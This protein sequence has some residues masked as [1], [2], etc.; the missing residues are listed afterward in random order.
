VLAAVRHT[1]GDGFDSLLPLPFVLIFHRLGLRLALHPGLCSTAVLYVLG[2]GPM[3]VIGYSVACLQQIRRLG[4]QEAEHQAEATH[5][6][7][8]GLHNRGTLLGQLQAALDRSTATGPAVAVL[9]LDLDG[10]KQVNDTFGHEA[11]DLVL[12]AVASALR[13]SVLGSDTIGRLGGDEFAVVLS[14]VR[15][16]GQAEAVAAGILEELAEPIMISGHP[17]PIGGSIGIALAGRPGAGAAE[18]LRRAG[19]AMY[20]AKRSRGSRWAV[21]RPHLEPAARVSPQ[22]LRAAVTTGQL[23]LAYQP[24]V[25][26]ATGRIAGAEALVRWDHPTRGP[27]PPAEFVPV[28]QESGLIGLVGEWVMRTACLQLAAWRAGIPGAGRIWLGVNVA[29]EQLQDPRTAGSVVALIEGLGIPPDR[30]VLEVTETVLMGSAMARISLEALHEAGVRIAIDDFGTGY[31]ALPY[32]TRLPVDALKLDRAFVAEL[33][34]GGE[35]AA[36]A[37]AVVRLAHTLRVGCTAEGVET[38]AQA[39]ELRALGYPTAQ[40]YYFGAPLSAERLT[41]LL[42]D[43][44]PLAAVPG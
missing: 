13:R 35:G 14:N 42:A 44:A 29:A 21:Y 30:L 34:G 38:A 2:W 41:L 26:L 1:L 5:D 4:P 3:M 10:F 32:L 31:S 12:T 11:G 25:N 33:D 8:T 28:A 43:P 18:L 16:A 15:S 23:Y 7:L 20:D 22:E 27:L 19:L 9:F 6:M 37:Q 39:A 17:M 40:G 36:V 24:I